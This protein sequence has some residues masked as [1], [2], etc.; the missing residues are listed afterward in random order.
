VKTGNAYDTDRY[1]DFRLAPDERRLA[2]AR[3]DLARN[4]ADLAIL[5]LERRA[6]TPL[7]SSS[8]TDATPVW[9]ANGDRL[10]F[11]SNRRG[12]HDLFIRPAHAGAEE[13]LLYKSSAGMYPTDWSSDGT[14]IIFHTLDPR[15]KHDIWSLNPTTG[16]ARPVLRTPAHEAQGQLSRSGRLAYTSNELGEPH[17]HVRTLDGSAESL[18]ASPNGGF[19]PRWRA[20]GHELF[21]IS[22]G[23]LMAVDVSVAGRLE[24]RNA[25]ALF[26]IPIQQ[27][28]AP[29]LSDF[30]VSKDGQRFLVK[31]PAD[32]NGAGAITIT[33][34][35][36]GR[37]RGSLR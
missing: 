1:V 34:N 10:V 31:V 30:V 27:T 33:L 11:R 2:V 18:N 5:D 4:T 36:P 22:Q 6:L 24:V 8:Q 19:D 21:F 17:V 35:W 7:A 29:Y 16:S 15:T 32:P 3:V 25:K 12:V 26:P 20:D 14:S 37:L 9:S 13:Q 23:M 28:S